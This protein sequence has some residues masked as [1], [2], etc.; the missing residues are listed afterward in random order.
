MTGPIA[1]VESCLSNIDG[2]PAWLTQR[3]K[4]IL[5]AVDPPNP[6]A[7]RALFQPGLEQGAGVLSCLQP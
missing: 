2:Y 3:C 7:R 5:G 6:D 1:L 4:S